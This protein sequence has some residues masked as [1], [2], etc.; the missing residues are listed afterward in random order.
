MAS[1]CPRKFLTMP[2]DWIE[3]LVDVFTD[4]SSRLAVCCEF[5]SPEQFP[6]E[7]AEKTL[8][9]CVVPAITTLTHARLYM[10]CAEPIGVEI[11]AIGR[12]SI[13]MIQES[14]DATTSSLR[15]IECF[16]GE[17]GVVALAH[18]M[19]NNAS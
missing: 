10:K 18:R 8:G 2:S 14:I 7:C 5:V 4:D 17:P 11:T 1:I 13:R 12:S 16:Q 6:F 9:D 19:S 3:E 15:I